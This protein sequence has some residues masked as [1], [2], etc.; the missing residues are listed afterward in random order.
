M[1]SPQHLF[2]RPGFLSLPLRAEPVRTVK[3]RFRTG[4]ERSA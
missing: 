2:L 3:I 1:V 4:M